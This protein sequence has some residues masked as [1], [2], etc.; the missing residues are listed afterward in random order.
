MSQTSSVTMTTC[1]LVSDPSVRPPGPSTPHVVVGG[2]DWR[3]GK[4]RGGGW[5]GGKGRG[6]GLEGWTNKQPN[7][8]TADTDTDKQPNTTTADTDTEKDREEEGV[9]RARRD[10]FDSSHTRKT[11]PI[12]IKHHSHHS[13]HHHSHHSHSDNKLDLPSSLADLSF[14]SEYL[15]S[16]SPRVCRFKLTENV[17][18]VGFWWFVVVCGGLWWVVVVCDGLWWLVVVC[19]GLWWLVVVCGGLWW[20]VVSCGGLW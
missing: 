10:S 19:G 20:F 3:G 14:R 5:R 6:G 13:N 12:A 7:T 1:P 11:L 17:F 8:T 16:S 9:R 2:G 4:G 18:Q 15:S